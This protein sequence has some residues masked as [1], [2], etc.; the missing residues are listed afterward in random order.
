MKTS[1]VEAKTKLRASVVNSKTERVK[2][3]PQ[4]GQGL[5]RVALGFSHAFREELPQIPLK[6]IP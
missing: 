3:L 1:V 4:R 6:N 5:V 2:G